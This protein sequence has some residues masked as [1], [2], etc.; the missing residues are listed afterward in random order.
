M[1][2][3]EYIR[4]CDGD[5]SERLNRVAD[6]IA[7]GNER[8]ICLSGPTCSGKTTAA[9]M[10]ALRLTAGGRNVHVIS[11]DDFY[12]D[13]D[14]LHSLSQSKGLDGIDYDSVDTIDL[15]ALE[16]FVREVFCGEEIHCPV[17]DFRS[18][19]RTGFRTVN[20]KE[21]DLF[22]FEGI[23]AIY[24]QVTSLFEPIGYVSVYI[25]PLRELSV[26]GETLSPNRI[27]LLRRLVR[28]SNFRGASAEFTL[29][30]WESVREN[31]ERKIF[32]FA[33]SCKYKIDST[34]GYELGV[35]RPYLEKL[36]QNF[37]EG[38]KYSGKAKE[39]LMQMS[40]VE[41]ISSALIEEGSLYREF[42]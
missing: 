9:A 4:K 1:N 24:P 30:L 5:F 17:F 12:F 23:Q 41:P 13:R 15:R 18:G 29:H 28:D 39:I 31:E 33:D 14:Y 26:N 19:T 6:E 8:V 7:E 32:P 20:A 16:E 34:H 21:K 22:I 27:R 40:A 42:V 2:I 11:I 38:S 35:L 36:L 25:A 37:S 3:R 10:I